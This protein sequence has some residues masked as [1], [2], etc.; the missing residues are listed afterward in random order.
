[1]AH[2]KMQL[3]TDTMVP[4]FG[5]RDHIFFGVSSP[6]NE[7]NFFNVMINLVD[8]TT[9]KPVFN[10]FQQ[11]TVCSM[12][13]QQRNMKCS[14][15]AH[16]IPPWK[17]SARVA[18]T[19]NIYRALGLDENEKMELYGLTGRVFGGILDSDAVDDMFARDRFIWTNKQAPRFVFVGHDPNAGADC[20][21]GLTALCFIEGRTVV[22]RLVSVLLTALLLYQPRRNRRDRI[23]KCSGQ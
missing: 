16:M 12:C 20:H 6:L 3:F 19:A 10:V 9:K 4:I 7:N 18:L 11:T 14:H 23:G 17:S 8:E 13:Q 1:M 22:R 2:G 5:V 15:L 21:T